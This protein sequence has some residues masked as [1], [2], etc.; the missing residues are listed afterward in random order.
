M[1]QVQTS[2]L[3]PVVNGDVQPQPW[4]EVGEDLERLPQCCGAT[5][6]TPTAAY[7]QIS[8][9]EQRTPICLSRSKTVICSPKHSQ[10]TQRPSKM[11]TQMGIGFV[12]VRSL[13]AQRPVYVEFWT[14]ANVQWVVSAWQVRLR[15][16]SVGKPF[17]FACEGKESNWR[18]TQD[19]EGLSLRWRTLCMSKSF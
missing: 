2:P 18:R 3:P 8:S 1:R 10:V 4:R 11:W 9:Y 13:R 16:A 5:E 7:F 15:T 14:A 12:Y 17:K 19:P 6:P